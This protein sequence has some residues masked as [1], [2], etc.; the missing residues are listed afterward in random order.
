MKTPDN[1]SVRSTAHID[2]ISLSGIEKLLHRRRA[3]VRLNPGGVADPLDDDVVVE[4][5]NFSSP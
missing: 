5:V 4:V 2:E 3:P 1:V